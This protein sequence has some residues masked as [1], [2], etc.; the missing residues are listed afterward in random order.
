MLARMS[1]T[2]PRTGVTTAEPNGPNWQYPAPFRPDPPPDGAAPAPT[3]SRRIL[4]VAILVSVIGLLFGFLVTAAIVSDNNQTASPPPSAAAPTPT[5]PILPGLS[6]TTV[7]SGGKPAASDPHATALDNLV[8]RQSDVPVIDTVDPVPN[9][10]EV[11]GQATLDLCNGTFPSEGARTAR[12]QVEV[13]DSLGNAP[14][15]TEAVLYEHTPDGAQAF[16]E[17]Q[18]VAKD[19]PST[20]VVSPVGEP[21]VLTLF[22]AKPDDGWDHTTGVDRL[23]YDVTTT[24]DTGDTSHAVVVYLRRGRALMGLYF[25]EPGATQVAVNGETTIQDIVHVFEQRMAALPSN[26]ANAP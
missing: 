2:D 15:S 25:N 24:R 9:G 22:G 7:P 13:F 16:A 26:V 14:F 18:H 17:L 1:W 12:R 4:V 20:P 5:L 6:P 21:T 3:V 8:V 23:A 10:N 11:Q 19:C